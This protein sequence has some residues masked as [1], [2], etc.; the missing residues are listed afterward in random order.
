MK[1]KLPLLPLIAM[2]LLL[3]VSCSEEDDFMGSS[4]T[5]QSY[6]RSIEDVKAIAT[7]FSAQGKTRSDDF[8]IEV[9]TSKVLKMPNTR[10]TG[11][12]NDTL[13]YFISG[14]EHPLLISANK[15]CAPILATLDHPDASIEDA[16]NNPRN[17]NYGFLALLENAIAYNQYPDLSDFPEPVTRASTVVVDEVAPKVAVEWSQEN[18]FNRY[19]P[20][21]YPAGCVAIAA[22]QAFTV[23]RHCSSFNNVPLYYDEMIKVKNSSY[24]YDHSLQ[25]DIIAQFIRQIGYAVGMKYEAGGSGADTDD[26]IKLFT[27]GGM[28]NLSTDKKMIK[29]TLKNYKDGITIISSRTKKNGFLGIKRGTGHAYIAD[30]F[31]V[32]QDGSD[33]IHVN[34]GWGPKYNGYFLTRLAAP[35]FTGNATNQF[36]HE[37]HFYSLYKK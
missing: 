34:Y 23:T 22:A 15:R 27:F 31:K 35:Y 9:L 17:E 4:P 6:I 21:F 16:I 26:A 32:F 10:S 7:I 11:L 19:S 30:G 14:I 24:Q 2:F 3:L 25:T 18:P 1:V 13:L 20:N 8:K 33:L 37:W 12:N 36:P 28:M 29:S 5:S